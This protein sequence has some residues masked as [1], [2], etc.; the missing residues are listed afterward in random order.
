M[1]NRALRQRMTKLKSLEK[2]EL[3]IK[4]R[5]VRDFGAFVDEA[6]HAVHYHASPLNASAPLPSRSR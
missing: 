1:D 3:F 2:L 5:R 6:S 4:V